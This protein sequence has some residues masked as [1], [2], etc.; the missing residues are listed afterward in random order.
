MIQSIACN[1]LMEA[2]SALR[3]SL[4]AAR[5]AQGGA[6]GQEARD[7]ALARRL[8]EVVAGYPDASCIGFYWP[9][10]GE[11]DARNAMAV[12][13][14]LK[15]SRTAALPVVVAP[16]QPLV[17]HAWRADSAMKKGRFGIAVPEEERV[18]VPD[19]LLVPCVGF[20]A[21]RY[22]LGYGGGYYDRTLA[23]WPG[24]RKPTTIGVAFESAKCDA[25]PRGEFDLPLGVIVTECGVY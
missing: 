15:A 21:E 8:M 5:E 22:R 3:A 13:L 20:D 24:E 10:A 1:P 17:F 25:L 18:V 12:W 16:R 7:E 6:A 11:F 4:L 19:L 9:V 2:K 23:V 14:A